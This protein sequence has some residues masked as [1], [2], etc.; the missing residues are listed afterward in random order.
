[1]QQKHQFLSD[2][3]L[4]FIR[5]NVTQAISYRPFLSRT[6]FLFLTV[7]SLW[8][9]WDCPIFVGPKIWIISLLVPPCFELN[10]TS[11][12]SYFSL[13]KWEIFPSFYWPNSVT[14]MPG[15]QFFW[16]GDTL[17]ETGGLSQSLF[18]INNV[19]SY[20]WVFLFLF[21]CPILCTSRYNKKKKEKIEEHMRNQEKFEH[22]QG[23][24]GLGME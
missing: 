11:H 7:F 10:I 3:S 20:K 6:R 9:L 8:K 5:R 17:S 24:G 18:K 19:S 22:P 12:I 13:K 23:N 4:L 21:M 16:G 15:V 2:V 14:K 1:M